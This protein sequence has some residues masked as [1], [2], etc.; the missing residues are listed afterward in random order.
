MSYPISLR[1]YALLSVLFCLTLVACGP[2]AGGETPLSSAP[3][4][5]L[6]ALVLPGQLAEFTALSEGFME[7]QPEISIEIRSSEQ[8]VPSSNSWAD[9]VRSLAEAADVFVGHEVDP[10]ASGLEQHVLDLRPWREADAQFAPD[11]I[12][13]VLWSRF[14]SGQ[15]LWA[16]PVE[17]RL[18]GIAYRRALFDAAGVPYP[19]DDWSWQDLEHAARML[20]AP[21][22]GVHGLADPGGLTLPP[23][24]A[25]QGVDLADSE[26]LRNA[27]AKPDSQAAQAVAAYAALVDAGVLVGFGSEQAPF[28]Q[29]LV[30]AGKA[31]MWVITLGGVAVDAATVGV[32]PFPEGS[33]AS[34]QGLYISARAEHPEAAWRWVRYVSQHYRPANAYQAPARASLADA[35]GYWDRLGPAG[36][37]A[38]ATLAALRPMGV[39][40]AAWIALRDAYEV[41]EYG[42][43]VP[44]P[45]SVAE[46]RAPQAPR[47]T[48]AAPQIPQLA[49]LEGNAAPVTIVDCGFPPDWG[50]AVRA[51][52]AAQ[53]RV[54][55]TLQ[56]TPHRNA[57]GWVGLPELAAGCDCFNWSSEVDSAAPAGLIRNLQPFADADAG[58]DAADFF[59]PAIEAARW[60][61]DLWALPFNANPT[62]LHYNKGL[63]DQ[64]GLAYPDGTWRWDDFLHAAQQLTHATGETSAED[65]VWGFLDILRPERTLAILIAQ[66]GGH[67]VDNPDRPTRPTL[68]SPEVVAAVQWYVSLSR[69]YGVTPAGMG[70]NEDEDRVLRRYEMVGRGRAGMWLMSAWWHYDAPGLRRPGA[71]VGVAPLPVAK[72][73][74]TLWFH[75]LY[76]VS[77]QSA[78]PEACWLWLRYMTQRFQPG[79]GAPAQLTVMGSLEYQHHVGLGV[80]EA[81]MGSY[82]YAPAPTPW[83]DSDVEGC[84][85]AYFQRALAAIDDGSDVADALRRA[86]VDA[87]KA[88]AESSTCPPL[89]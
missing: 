62:V 31:G 51:F 48:L 27:L 10:D 33:G 2:S 54:R 64:A 87:E 1:T 36:A 82:D 47:P 61:G 3:Q 76:Y 52:N 40:G 26:G 23:Y 89:R 29:E 50:D 79:S 57:D 41:A 44:T 70:F 83:G 25:A 19:R 75:N 88:L 55:V 53:D 17:G 7:A 28:A 22:A 38:R 71:T 86:Q 6:V 32:A 69:D 21:D 67:L 12:S 60:Q 30:A 65:A 66:H 35:S 24:V 72:V 4:V 16:V 13:G 59:A 42:G 78:H 9:T 81:V 63:F 14:T 43:A 80:V 34:F 45:E 85:Y 49:L 8:V 5:R 46:P 58:F 18:Q 68:D 77:A 37:A 20:A 56:A 73:P 74:A 11:D 15:G 84:A 39:P